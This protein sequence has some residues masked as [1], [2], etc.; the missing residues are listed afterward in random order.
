MCKEEEARQFHEYLRI[1]SILMH[2]CMGLYLHTSQ[3]LRRKSLYRP[4]LLLLL[5]TSSS[6]AATYIHSKKGAK[7]R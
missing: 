2:N 4:V 5:P 7:M 1:I 3:K 6:P